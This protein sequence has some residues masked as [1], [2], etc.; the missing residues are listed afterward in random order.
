MKKNLMMIRVSSQRNRNNYQIQTNLNLKKPEICQ[1]QI[2][3]K[4]VL[5][6]HRE[7]QF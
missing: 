2:Q 7:L 3:I 1:V 5:A 6:K 4:Q